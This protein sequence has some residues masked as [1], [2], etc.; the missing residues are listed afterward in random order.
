MGIVG[1]VVQDADP[2]LPGSPVP[3]VVWIV[4]AVVFALLGAGLAHSRRGS[5]VLGALLGLCCGPFGLL[6]VFRLPVKGSLR[7]IDRRAELLMTGPE[8]ESAPIS[9]EVAEKLG[10]PPQ[11]AWS[12]ERPD[13]TVGGGG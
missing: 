12:E 6:F 13:G 10:L 5:E 11:V 3:P 7:D 2:A 8:L 1:L 9:P 4:A